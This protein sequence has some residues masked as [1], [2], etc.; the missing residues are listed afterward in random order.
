MLLMWQQLKVTLNF[1]YS[2]NYFYG[3]SFRKV[4][5]LDKEIKFDGIS[6]VFES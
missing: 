5:Q 2:F 1:L 4:V 3:E 6:D